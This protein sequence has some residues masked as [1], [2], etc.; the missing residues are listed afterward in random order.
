MTINQSLTIAM[1]LFAL[2][3]AGYIDGDTRK[4][5]ASYCDKAEPVTRA[6]QAKF[7]TYCKD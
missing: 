4:H 2:L 7:S 1:L 5:M 6:E 3:M